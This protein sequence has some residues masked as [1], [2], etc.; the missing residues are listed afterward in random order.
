MSDN[1]ATRE[2]KLA[3]S[4]QPSDRAKRLAPTLIEISR[5]ILLR[6]R[7]DVERELGE[8]HVE[9]LRQA[10]DLLRILETEQF[11][12]RE[13]IKLYHHGGLDRSALNRI[14]ATWNEEP[15]P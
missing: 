13:A 14:A 2:R 5:E 12:Q 9:R 6:A 7:N 1:L 8:L 10:S 15:K 4:L 3:E 11:R